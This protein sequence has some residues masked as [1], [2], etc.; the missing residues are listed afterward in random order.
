MAYCDIFLT[1]NA[2]SNNCITILRLTWAITAFAKFGVLI[3]TMFYF[4]FYRTLKYE[5]KVASSD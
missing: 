2:S 4:I 3:S 1:L 5:L